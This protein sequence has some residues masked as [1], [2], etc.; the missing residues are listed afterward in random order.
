MTVSMLS[1][2]L[3]GCHCVRLILH[4]VFGEGLD[5]VG[6]RGRGPTDTCFGTR[7]DQVKWVKTLG[8]RREGRSGGPSNTSPTQF[9]SKLR[10]T[11]R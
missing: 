3:L 6:E 1:L 5:T 11:V 7:P 8:V 2:S 10:H 9:F 4:S